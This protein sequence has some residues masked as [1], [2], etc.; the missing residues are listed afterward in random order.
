MHR[1]GLLL[2]GA[3]AVAAGAAIALPAG[4]AGGSNSGDD[5]FDTVRDATSR[6]RKVERAIDAGYAQFFGCVHEPLAG[7]KCAASRKFA[8]AW[9]PNP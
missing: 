4:L 1:R 7:S 3:V 6:Y 9:R 8:Y 2:I 5:P